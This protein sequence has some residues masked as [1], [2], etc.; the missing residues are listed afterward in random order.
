[1]LT[2]LSSLDVL[3]SDPSR[4]GIFCDFDGTLSAIVDRPEDA[5]PVPGAAEL[6]SGLSR[7]FGVVAIISGRSLDDLRSRFAPD[8]VLLAGSYGRERSDRPGRLPAQDHSE[9]VAAA[10]ART[11]ALDGVGIEAKDTGVAIRYRLAPAHARDVEALATT[12]AAEFHMELR[13]GRKVVELTQ[14]GP[15]KAEALRD[16]VAEFELVSFLF[17]GDDIAD[18]EAFMWA[19]DTGRSCVLVGVRSEESPDVIANEADVV[20]DGPAAFVA[21]LRDLLRRPG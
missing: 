17:A 12:L 1:M 21:L 7:V 6:L 2:T 5:R 3:T 13:P 18:G 16:L 19:R 15:G 14:R 8:G 11:K 20:V 4:S 9:L 10:T